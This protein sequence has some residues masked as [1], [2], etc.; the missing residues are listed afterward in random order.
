MDHLRVHA[1][2]LGGDVLLVRQFKL[3][4]VFVEVDPVFDAAGLD[5]DRDVIDGGQSGGFSGRGFLDALVVRDVG[6]VRN[7]ALD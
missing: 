6:L 7:G 1:A 4:N 5:A 2:V 3:E